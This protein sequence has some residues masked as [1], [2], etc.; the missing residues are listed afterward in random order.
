MRQFGGILKIGREYKMRWAT[1]GI[2]VNEA[3][4]W[5][6]RPNRACRACLEDFDHL[7]PTRLKEHGGHKLLPLQARGL[8]LLRGLPHQSFFLI[9][10]PLCTVPETTSVREAII[11]IHWEYVTSVKSTSISVNKT[12]SYWLLCKPEENMT[13]ET[14]GGVL[15]GWGGG[16]AIIIRRLD[17]WVFRPPVAL[18]TAT[19]LINPT[20]AHQISVN[21]RS[22]E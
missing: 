2:A 19:P 17:L 15:G 14:V 3:S 16:A 5:R 20:K 8:P 4:R 11:Y 7:M 10:I 12:L 13:K 21:D 22:N 6:R 18:T 9:I 1:S